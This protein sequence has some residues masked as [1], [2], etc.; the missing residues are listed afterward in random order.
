MWIS[1]FSGSDNSWRSR[2]L[3]DWE[4]SH[5]RPHRLTVRALKME[6]QLGRQSGKKLKKR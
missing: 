3:T 1:K 2:V 4:S 6:I 5:Y